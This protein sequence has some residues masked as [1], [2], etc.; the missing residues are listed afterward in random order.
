ARS[1]LA[2][3]AVESV[4]SQN[5]RVATTLQACAAQEFERFELFGRKRD[6]DFSQFKVRGH[7]ENSGILR[8]YFQAMMWSGRI[9]LRIAGDPRLASP[10]ELGAALVLHDLLRR[11]GKFTQWQQFDRILH[12]FVGPTDSMTF[13]QLDEFLAALQLKSPGDI[14]DLSTLSNVQAAI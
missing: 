2:G 11:S 10:R 6:L 5:A 7:Y 8:R 4:L 9:D 14:K 12:T 13:G 1:L 3:K